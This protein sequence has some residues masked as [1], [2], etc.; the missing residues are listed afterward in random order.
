MAS[1]HSSVSTMHADSVD[2]LIKRLE[3]PPI[4][5]SPSLLNTLD[6]VAIMTHTLGGNRKQENS[7]K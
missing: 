3:T 7:G 6:C 1:G 5:L 4:E 2:T